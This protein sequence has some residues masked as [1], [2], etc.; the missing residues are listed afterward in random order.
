MNQ[1]VSKEELDKLKKLKGKVRGMSFKTT[2][3]FILKEKGKDG[4]KKFEEAMAML[5]YPIKYQEI[6][7]MDFYPLWADALKLLV[8]KRL[9]DFNN[10]KFQEMGRFESKISL[11]MRIFIQY[12]VS[13]K[14]AV[15]EAPRLW[16]KYF[17][18]GDLKVV[19]FDEQKRY[20]VFRIENFH[21]H[22]L[23]CEAQ[24]GYFPSILQI[25]VK[26]PVSCEE[27]KCI[28]R[29]DEYHEFLMK[30]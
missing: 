10:K 29:G 24:K 23:S 6:K 17:T 21:H 1:I 26:K 27:T 19:E 16:K 2:E 18:V 7:P 12:F 3:E 14:K 22:P 9:F 28:H 5:G 15:K 20:V 4:L 11:I 25:I 30:W 8:I 13:L